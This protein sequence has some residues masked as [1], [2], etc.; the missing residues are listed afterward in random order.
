MANINPILG[1]AR[2]L[3]NSLVARGR[4]ATAAEALAF[5]RI[6]VDMEVERLIAE[7]DM[8]KGFP[9]I[10]LIGTVAIENVRAAIERKADPA[11]SERLN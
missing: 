6:A 1:A 8:S 7:V 4:F 2:E 9:S 3:A 10:L 11:G 5:V